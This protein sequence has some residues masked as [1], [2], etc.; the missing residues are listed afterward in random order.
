M[1]ELHKANGNNVLYILYLH[2]QCI[3]C[4]KIMYMDQMVVRGNQF[5]AHCGA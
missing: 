4:I 5:L 3:F 1:T 2:L